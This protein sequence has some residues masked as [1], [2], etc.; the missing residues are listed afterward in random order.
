MN[1]EFQSDNII[2]LI[3][4]VEICSLPGVEICLHRVK[5]WLKCVKELQ[6]WMMERQLHEIK[7]SQE[8]AKLGQG[9]IKDL[10]VEVRLG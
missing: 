1:D 5:V 4:L 10:K 7:A 6:G 2:S 3:P 9:V 8:I